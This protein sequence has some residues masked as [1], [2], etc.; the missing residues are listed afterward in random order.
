MRTYRDWRSGG[1]TREY[2]VGEERHPGDVVADVIDPS[3][4]KVK[5]VVHEADYHELQDGMTV[6]IS[7]PAYPGHVFT[8]KLRQLGAI[9][10]DRNRV[11]PTSEGGRDSEIAMFNA[12]IDMDSDGRNF[13]PGMSAI[14]KIRVHSPRERLLIPRSAIVRL[15]DGRNAVRLVG[16]A[17]PKVVNSQYF[18]DLYVE[19]P[20]GLQAGDEI[21][22]SYPLPVDDDGGAVAKP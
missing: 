21:L 7:L 4:M 3:R 2:S 8:G 15:D 12:E 22:L 5:L 11:D 20:A 14:I 1:Q 17:E 10:R 6:E 13:H 16:E 19:I 9:G 18:N